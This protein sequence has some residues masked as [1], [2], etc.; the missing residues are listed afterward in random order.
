MQV[1]CKLFS[2]VITAYSGTVA[3]PCGSSTP[4]TGTTAAASALAGLNMFWS[5]ASEPPALEWK[6]G[7]NYSPSL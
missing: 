2:T 5:E 6:N 3:L 1:R 7:L 4:I